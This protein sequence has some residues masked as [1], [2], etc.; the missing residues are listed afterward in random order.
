MKYTN[1]NK[2]GSAANINGPKKISALNALLTIIIIVVGLTYLIQ[3][4]S[5]ATKGYEIKELENEIYT[6]EL[7]TSDLQ[8]LTLE[9]Q[10]MNNIQTKVTQLNMVA[11]GQAEYLSPKPVARAQ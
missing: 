3:I 1:K 7:E 10:S 6:L 8:S 4:N 11:V 5:L 9:L 2:K